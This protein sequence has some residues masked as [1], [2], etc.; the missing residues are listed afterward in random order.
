MNVLNFWR[1]SCKPTFYGKKGTTFWKV[2]TIKGLLLNLF[3]NFIYEIIWAIK[4]LIRRNIWAL[5]FI[6]SIFYILKE[7][8][9]Y[10][11]IETNCLW[12]IWNKYDLYRLNPYAA[13]IIYIIIANRCKQYNVSQ[14]I[15]NSVGFCSILRCFLLSKEQQNFFYII[16]MFQ[17]IE[18]FVS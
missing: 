8:Y 3:Y 6:L 15:H 2:Q 14:V 13:T 10:W 16:P 7:L 12:F 1:C 4:N 11:I 5:I 18:I 17:K 9:F